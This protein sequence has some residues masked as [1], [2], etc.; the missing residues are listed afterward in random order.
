[1]LAVWVVGD[2]SGGVSTGGVESDNDGGCSGKMGADSVFVLSTPLGVVAGF[3]FLGS[4][5][6]SGDVAGVSSNSSWEV[7]GG[8]DGVLS[9]TVGG[10]VMSCRGVWGSVNGV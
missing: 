10:T 7:G 3:V 4:T 1:M 6:W 9:V 5:D 8:R 2:G